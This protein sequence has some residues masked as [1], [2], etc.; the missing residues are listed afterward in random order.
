MKT[1]YVETGSPVENG[2]VGSFDGKL[3]DECWTERSS[4]RRPE[5]KVLAE[6]FRRRAYN[7]VRPQRSPADIGRLRARG[8][9]AVD[10][11]LRS[12]APRPGVHGQGHRGT[13]IDRGIIG[14]GGPDPDHCRPGGPG[15]PRS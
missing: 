10:A 12:F 5:A 6:R 1:L 3:S 14:G 15:S 4:T 8:D 13:I 2:Y 11:G 9:R 7:T